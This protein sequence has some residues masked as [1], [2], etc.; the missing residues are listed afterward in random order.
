VEAPQQLLHAGAR[1]DQPDTQVAGLARHDRDRLEQRAVG[2]PEAPRRGQRPG[3]RREQADALPGRRGLG[4][5]AQ[6][7]GEPVGRAVGRA[8][9]HRLAGLTQDRD[10]LAV[11][12]TGGVLDVVGAR[13]GRRSAGGQRVGAA[14]VRAEPPAARRS[15][16]RRVTDERVA[17]AEAARHVGRA[18][19]VAR[20]QLVEG[21]ERVAL[22]H[23][24][25]GRRQLG[26]ERVAGHGGTLEHAA[27]A[28]AEQRQLVGQRGGDGGRHAGD[29][30]CGRRRA[31]RPVR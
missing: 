26:L 12:V 5:E 18:H 13:R 27:G 30:V 8:L 19:E 9:E 17:E 7:G 22:G 24:G 1:R 21:G 16:V 10:R 29:G 20:E 25:G 11:A 15:L 6:R 3:E 4:Q 2:L 31:A 14:L 23:A 28:V